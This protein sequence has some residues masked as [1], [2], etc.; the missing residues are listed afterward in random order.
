VRGSIVVVSFALLAGAAAASAAAPSFSG[1]VCRLLT[2]AQ[3]TAVKGLSSRC[4]NGKPAPA[5]GGRNYIGNWAAKS[6]T[7][8]TLQ[9]TVSK[10]TDSGWLARAKSN[11]KQGLVATPKKVAG[12]GSAAYEAAGPSSAEVRF[13][14]GK[15]IV[16]VVFSARARPSLAPVEKLAKTIAGEL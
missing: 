12:I 9:V 6:G 10:Y 7:T 2:A 13:V 3:M 8:P 1:N 14:K 4:A 16:D 5:P 15:D 11:L